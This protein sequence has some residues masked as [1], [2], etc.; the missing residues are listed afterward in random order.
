MSSRGGGTDIDNLLAELPTIDHRE[1][2]DS[3]NTDLAHAPL[4]QT[5]MRYLASTHSHGPDQPAVTPPSLRNNS[6]RNELLREA[7]FPN[8]RNDASSD[9]EPNKM[10]EKD[11]L[12]VSIWK[13]YSRTKTQLPN[14][15]RMDNL[16]WRMMAMNLKRKEREQARCVTLLRPHE[17]G[18]ID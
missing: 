4:S 14:Q 3:L 11:P 15:E 13:L 12:G 2:N 6:T 5:A 16:T 7:I 8:W 10:M 9:L 1:S 17:L 18:G